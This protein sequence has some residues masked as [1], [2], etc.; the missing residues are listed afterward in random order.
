MVKTLSLVEEQA[1][2]ILRNYA[3]S[4]RKSNVTLAPT[5]GPL[6]WQKSTSY[7]GLFYEYTVALY[8]GCQF[9]CTYCYVPEVQRGLPSALGGWGGYV[10]VRP[11]GVALLERY[12]EELVGKT[13]FMSATTDPYQWVERDFLLTRAGLEKLA[14]MDFSYLLISTRSNLI[15]RDI[16]ILTDKRFRGRIEV[17]ISISSDIPGVRERLEPKTPLYRKRFEVAQA[18]RKHGIPVRIHAAPLAKY[19][20]DYLHMISDCADWAWFDGADYGASKPGR[21]AGLLYEHGEARRH[22]EDARLFLGEQRVG[23]GR[24]HF[25]WKWDHTHQ[26]ITS[27]PKREGQLTPPRRTQKGKAHDNS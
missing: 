10:R 1:E 18:L 9:G 8:S 24:E 15:L 5:Q 13:L 11:H 14:G 12:K 20:A 23:F 2:Q 22:A 7:V 26:G 6:I 21:N 4:H 16:D 17:G 19:S 3:E 27:L 25:G